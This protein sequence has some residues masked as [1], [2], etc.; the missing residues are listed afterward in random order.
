MS[1]LHR[2]A[3]AKQREHVLVLQ[4]VILE[5]R[6]VQQL[7]ESL[8]NHVAKHNIPLGEWRELQVAER[9]LESGRLLSVLDAIICKFRGIPKF[10][11][12]SGLGINQGISQVG[13]P[14]LVLVDVF[15][16]HDVVGARAI[17]GGL[18]FG[19]TTGQD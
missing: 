15:V 3:P 6:V 8:L 16:K 1:R 12:R 9:G 4:E 14:S 2:T 18:E 7:D 13:E 17:Q 19:A 10:S 5:V 11:D